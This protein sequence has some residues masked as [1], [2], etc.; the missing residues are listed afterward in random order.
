MVN[1]LTEAEAKR[2]WDI[3]Q[4]KLFKILGYEPT[5]AEW[6][7]H[8]FISRLKLIAGGIRGGK[9]LVNVRELVTDWFCNIDKPNKLYWLLG[10]DYEGTRGE[11]EH[12]VEDFKKLAMLA[13]PPTK[14]IDPGLMLLKDGTRIV[15]KSAMY[16]EKIATVAPDGILICEAAQVD[17]EIYLRAKERLAEKRGWLCMAGTFEGSLGWYPELFTRW[18]AYNEEGAK[19][20]SLPTWS[21]TVIFPGGRQDPEIIRAEL[22]ETP[23]RF[24]ERYGGVPCP[25]TGRVIKEFS[26]EIHVGHYPFDPELPVEI[27]VDPGWRW[28]YAV[29]AIQKWGEQIVLIDEIYVQGLGHKDVILMATKKPWWNAV[30]GG[31]IDIAATQHQGEEPV[32]D[33]WGAPRGKGGANIWLRTKKVTN[34]EDGI[35][36]LRV[37]LKQHPVT[38]APGILVNSSC[39]G[40]IAECGGGKSPIDGMG[41]WMREPNTLKA[42]DRNNHATKAVIYYLINKFGYLGRES[43]PMAGKIKIVRNVPPMTFVR[44]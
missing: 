1:D 15:T 16:P 9:S 43:T 4:A 28:A 36:L 23:E 13:S 18:Q 37:Y 14:N 5:T 19:S 41:M 34:V 27:A 29:V 39:K 8:R 26:N 17:Y 10:K 30:I 25:P 12:L 32:I 38:G 31:A 33:I 24:A 3:N 2:F 20:F 40:F 44:T 21:N 6:A 22:R 11:W 7:I 42:I 35:D